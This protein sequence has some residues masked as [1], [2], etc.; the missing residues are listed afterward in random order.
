MNLQDSDIYLLASKVLA[1]LFR[2]CD[3]AISKN[4]HGS[5]TIGVNKG[6][7]LSWVGS[8]VTVQETNN[9]V[10][11]GRDEVGILEQ[12]RQVGNKS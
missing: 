8:S 12:L 7:A 9:L 6:L 10:Q 5:C 2:F 3:K 4:R 11:D 1:D